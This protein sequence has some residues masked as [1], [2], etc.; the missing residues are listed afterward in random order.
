[1]ESRRVFLG[2]LAAAAVMAP[3]LLHRQLL[4]ETTAAVRVASMWIY[5]WDL[6]DEGYDQV[7]PLLRAH[8]LTSISLATAYHAGKFLSPHNPRHKVI[9]L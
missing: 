6:V 1:M 8:G 7:L 4:A 2:R 5:P 9:F 3:G